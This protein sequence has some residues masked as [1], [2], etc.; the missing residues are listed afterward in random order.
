ME[1]ALNKHKSCHYSCHTQ[2]KA[3]VFFLL[4]VFLLVFLFLLFLFLHPSVKQ[5]PCILLLLATGSAGRPWL[6]QMWSL[7]SCF[8]NIFKSKRIVQRA[9]KSGRAWGD[10]F[11]SECTVQCGQKQICARLSYQTICTLCLWFF[12]EY[13]WQK[14]NEIKTTATTMSCDNSIDVY[15]CATQQVR[16]YCQVRFNCSTVAPIPHQ[17]VQ[18]AVG[19][20][21]R[22]QSF[23]WSPQRTNC[24]RR[25]YN[26]SMWTN[27]DARLCGRKICRLSYK[28]DIESQ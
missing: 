5:Q 19:V 6:T 23:H 16:R 24:H 12:V 2:H 20:F 3:S 1:L 26:L 21:Q 18:I 10:L 7:F 27:R 22:I 11:Y 4:F 28:F 9:K 13:R 15:G 17:Q 25:L 8:S 14:S